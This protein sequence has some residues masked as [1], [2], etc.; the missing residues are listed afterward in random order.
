MLALKDTCVH[1]NS[2]QKYIKS[3]AGG[4]DNS[5]EGIQVCI[6]LLLFPVFLIIHICIDVCMICAITNTRKGRNHAR[7]RHGI[8]QCG[9]QG[10]LCVQ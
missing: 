2:Q 10:V 1:P 6:S 3:V 4:A 8:R 5:P 7:L 9:R